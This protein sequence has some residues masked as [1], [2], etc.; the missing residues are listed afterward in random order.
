MAITLQ[1]QF[2]INIQSV[3]A[4]SVDATRSIRREERA[5][6]EA[7][8]QRAIADGLS[9]DEQVRIREQQLASEKKSGFSDAS[10]IANLEKSIT[11]TKKLARFSKYREKYVTSLGDLSS[12]KI[13]E[14]QYLKSLKQSITDVTDPGLR[15]EIQNNIAS[16]EKMVKQYHDTILNNKI[17]KAKYDGTQ[18]SLD[19]VLTQIKNARAKALISDSQDEVTAYNET[20]S[21]VESQLSGV[22]VQNSIT[23]FQVQSS[24]RGMGA[25]EKL[26]YLNS[27][28]SNADSSKPVKI[29]NKSY[30]S[31]Q[32]F[33]TLQ[34]DGYL[35]GTSKTFGSFFNEIKSST[36]DTVDTSIAKFGYPPQATLDNALSVF[37]DLKTRPE[38][39]PYMNKVD[40]TQATVMT[41]AVDKFA[42]KVIDSSET[43]LQFED[44]INQLKNL[45]QKYG[46]NT[47]VYT[48]K[49]FQRVRGLEQSRLIKS[50][51]AAN[52][53]K[54]VSVNIP[55]ITNVPTPTQTPTDTNTSNW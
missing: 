18:K 23:D 44:G 45:G 21:A 15:L 32:E 6:K 1:K 50:G 3:V 54:E 55:D 51:T 22:K 39:A 52:I 17:K 37:N 28:L 2:S 43:S 48:S 19:D 46:V 10:Y 20:I 29:G 26:N 7:E 34:R 30:S 16:A 47:E 35:A 27:E 8:F 40:I 14:E 36:Q 25:I 42:K 5:Q 53:A 33:W 41:D 13:N 38:I 49:L 24:T 12:G 11:D 9:Y 31:E 4:Q